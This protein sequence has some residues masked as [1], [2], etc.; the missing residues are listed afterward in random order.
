MLR[1]LPARRAA[2]DGPKVPEL[3]PPTN[4]AEQGRD[5]WATAEEA[6]PPHA[7]IR[8]TT[9]EPTG[10]TEGHGQREGY[11]LGPDVL[12]G[13]CGARQP[14][15]PSPGPHNLIH[16]NEGGPPEPAGRVRGLVGAE[17]PPRRTARSSYLQRYSSPPTHQ[18]G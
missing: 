4:G 17:R 7:R 11:P 5:R 16:I 2:E 13:F 6:K 10:A 15:L 12:S 18:T 9:A 3:K 1:L 8:R 14:K